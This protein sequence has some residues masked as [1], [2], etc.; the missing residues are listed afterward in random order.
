MPSFECCLWL[1]FTKRAQNPL[2]IIH[3]YVTYH[4][5]FKRELYK[6][7]YFTPCSVVLVMM[8]WALRKG[9]K[10]ILGVVNEAGQL[11]TVINW[12]G[13]GALTHFFLADSVLVS[14]PIFRNTFNYK[15]RYLKK[16][17][18]LRNVWIMTYTGEPILCMVL[19]PQSCSNH[20]V[21]KKKNSAQ[22]TFS[23]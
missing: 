22:S 7:F 20:T 15:S 19:S 3:H 4:S 11:G 6:H 21:G 1:T 9:L 13:G 23:S 18:P 5:R 2:M 8:T 14:W 16:C 10:L 12:M 17:I